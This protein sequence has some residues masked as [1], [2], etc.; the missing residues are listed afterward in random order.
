MLALGLSQPQPCLDE[1]ARVH[2][3]DG[4]P[5]P[6]GPW[7]SVRRLIDGR[8]Q[9]RVRVALA[10]GVGD[11]QGEGDRVPAAGIVVRHFRWRI[12]APG[13]ARGRPSPKSSD[14]LAM[15]TGGPLPWIA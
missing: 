2:L 8:H 11:R 13:P 15:T 4:G 3:I 5:A 7:Y 12:R 10:G 1:L 9:H 14:Q 6:P